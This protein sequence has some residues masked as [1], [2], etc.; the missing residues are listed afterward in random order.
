MGHG[1]E[2]AVPGLADG[3]HCP[4]PWDDY[5]SALCRYWGFRVEWM[6]AKEGCWLIVKSWFCLNLETGHGLFQADLYYGG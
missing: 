3:S 6:G 2:N 5:N 1:G 4:L